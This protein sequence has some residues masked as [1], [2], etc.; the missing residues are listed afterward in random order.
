MQR[1]EALARSA[2][3]V[4]AAVASSSFSPT[5]EAAKPTDKSEPFGYC[6]NT[7]TIRGQ[8]LGLVEEIEI[9][10]KA[11]YRG[12]E[13]WLREIEQYLQAGGSLRD[14]RKRIV[15]AGLTVASAIGFA[16]WI[17]DDD[18]Q[19]AKGLEQAKRDMGLI[20]ELGGKFIAAPAAGAKDKHIDPLRAAERYRALCIV[21]DSAGVS[22]EVEVWGHS[23]T[24]GRLGE[25]VFVAIES[26]HP[27]ACLLPDVYHLHKGGSDFQGLSLLAGS[28]MHCFHV[29]DYPDK[30]RDQLTD[31]DRVYPGDGV[32]PLA[33]VF[34][35][36][37]A[38]GFD[39]MLSLELFNKSYWQQD[40]LT[41]ARTGL[42]KTRAAVQ[43]ALA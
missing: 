25:A 43:K 1:R 31:A 14:L 6:L 23:S 16:E 15:D 37:A 39:G 9:A 36:L 13:P 22:P 35:T 33:T 8:G 19:R 29:N 17:V 40:A 30:P 12:I 11:G 42:E 4:G 41:V 20:A 7:S 26:G 24:L 27:R 10:A 5:A 3:L 28:A 38:I 34:R 2:A 21:G 18:A 32:A